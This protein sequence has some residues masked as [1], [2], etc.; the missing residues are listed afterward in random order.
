MGEWESYCF[1]PPFGGQYLVLLSFNNPGALSLV[2]AGYEY[3][4]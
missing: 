1:F 3:Y 2:V 4:P